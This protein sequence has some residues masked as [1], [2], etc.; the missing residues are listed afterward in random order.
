MMMET[1]PVMQDARSWNEQDRLNPP[2]S[3]LLI[4]NDHPI[5]LQSS[6]AVH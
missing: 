1:K 3:K 4:V 6:L 5:L 2:T